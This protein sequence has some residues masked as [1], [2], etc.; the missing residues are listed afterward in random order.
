MKKRPLILVC[1]DDG[2]TAPGIRILIEIMNTLGDVVVVAPDNPRSGMGH[3]ITVNT[4]LTCN[5][6]KVDNGPQKEYSC[7]GTPADCIK[8]AVHQIL[9]RKPDLCVSGINHG[10]N[11]SINVIYSGTMSAAVEA[12]IESIP[13]IG[14]SLLDYSWDAD[15]TP[16]KPYVKNLAEQVLK[17]GLPEGVVLN[18]NI[19]KLA[20]T[21]IKGVKVSRQARGNWKEVFDKRV[22]PQ[23]EDYYWLTGE[24][25]NLDHGKDTDLWA[26][27]NGYISV[28]PVM[29]DMTAYRFLGELNNWNFSN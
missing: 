5:P 17:N 13:A 18:V 16:A 11:S 7:S 23:G 26:L 15:F 9:K 28:V 14:F 20:K 24:M 19:P 8:M 2:I 4:T 25:V 21:A 6:T 1:N 29:F 27:E 12:G 22:S 3:A 10:A